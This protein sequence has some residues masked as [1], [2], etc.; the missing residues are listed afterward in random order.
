MIKDAVSNNY[1]ML[2]EIAKDTTKGIKE[3]VD[4]YSK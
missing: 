2:S 1:L 3:R 4:V